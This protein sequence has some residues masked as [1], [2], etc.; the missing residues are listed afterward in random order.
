[1]GPN[2]YGVGERRGRDGVAG[3]VPENTKTA[4]DTMTTK[5]FADARGDRSTSFEVS[6]RQ[7]QAKAAEDDPGDPALPKRPRNSAKSVS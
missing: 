6:I 2:H 7:A 4:K 5:A 1:M 3:A